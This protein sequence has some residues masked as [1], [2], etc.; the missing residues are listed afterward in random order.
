[1][2]PGLHQGQ[3][4][5]WKDE[6]GFGFIQAVNE[7]KEIFLHISE[8]KDSTR[9]PQ[10]GDTICYHIVVEDEKIRACNAFIL[11]ARSKLSSPSS[12][13]GNI[14]AFNDLSKY[15][16]PV[17]EVLFLSILPLIGSLHF[18]W[19]TVN[20][21]PL[22]LY[23]VMSVLTFVLYAVDKSQAKRGDWRTSE[24]TMH[25]CE[26]AG[27]WLGGFVAQRRLRHKNI[28]TSYQVVFWVIVALHT[29]FWL[30]WLFF[31]GKLIK[32]FLGSNFRR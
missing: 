32:V 7:N 4:T 21:I 9:R 30:D 15:P 18:F 1:M 3:L 28:K 29:T 6:R 25:L 10:V 31:G 17:L 20:P 23:P 12:P 8:L 24:R 5:K 27:G 2:K 11:G 26:L 16:F 14:A 19:I 13:L 22:V